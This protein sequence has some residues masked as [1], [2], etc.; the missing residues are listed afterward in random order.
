MT[1]ANMLSLIGRVRYRRPR[2]DH[3]L[4][5]SKGS[6]GASGAQTCHYRW[7]QDRLQS[8]SLHKHMSIRGL[9]SP[10][11]PSRACS[12]PGQT[13]KCGC[14][15]GATGLCTTAKYQQL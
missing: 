4:T 12:A 6:K 8:C 7:Y 14:R 13:P 3:A 11:V 15:T 5:C 2:Q 1:W 9:Q 10:V